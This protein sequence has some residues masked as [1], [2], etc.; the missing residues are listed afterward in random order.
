[1][2]FTPNLNISRNTELLYPAGTI[3]LCPACHLEHY[4]VLRDIYKKDH[5]TPHQVKSVSADVLDP[6]I[7]VH[8]RCQNCY[9][10]HTVPLV[11]RVAGKEFKRG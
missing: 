4:E 1:M 2:G 6:A 5:V 8:T 11:E 7:V 3:L 10:G 9:G